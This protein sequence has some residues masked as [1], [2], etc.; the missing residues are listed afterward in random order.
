MV[1]QRGV[2]LAMPCA[3]VHKFIQSGRR[4]RPR[5]RGSRGHIS[6]IDVM[7]L[8]E[9]VEKI[10]AGRAKRGCSTLFD[11]RAARGYF[12]PVISSSASAAASATISSRGSS[13]PVSRA[14]VKT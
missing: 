1:V 12:D 8:A 7:L 5:Y 10:I 6:A 13:R 2:A 3:I 4:T 14:A 11:H 9:L